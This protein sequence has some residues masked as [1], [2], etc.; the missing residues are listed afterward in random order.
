MDWVAH[1]V[2]GALA[3]RERRQASAAS[4]GRKASDPG[5]APRHLKV[6]ARG[7]TLAYWRLRCEGYAI[8][9]RNRRP[10]GRSGE[11]D[12]VGWDGPVLAFIEVKTRTSEH[13]GPP[14]MALS[15][16]QQRRIVK[17]ARVYMRR[18]TK[19]PAGYRFDIAS[20]MWDPAGG[21]RVRVIKDAFKE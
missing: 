15:F 7:E 9:T 20:V 21:Y 13:A 17:S 1:L 4:R 19:Q 12:L 6:G 3:W 8:V 16:E 10:H 18:L 5:E 14:E 2:Y 11:L